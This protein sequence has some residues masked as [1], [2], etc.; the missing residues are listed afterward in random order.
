VQFQEGDSRA[1]G[2]TSYLDIRPHD[3]TLEIGW[4]WL[5]PAAW[6][7]GVNTECV[8]LMM[9]HAFETWNVGRIAIK[10]D[11]RNV[12]SRKSIEKI[13]ATYEGTWRNHRLLSTGKYRDSAFYSVIDSEWPSVREHLLK[14][15]S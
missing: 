5:T 8:Y 9:R 6:G 4:A 1:I 15:T 13:G 14:L 2:S 11:A 10:A 7:T 3:R 12:R